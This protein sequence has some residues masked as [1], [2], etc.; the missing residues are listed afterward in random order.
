MIS[1][2]QFFHFILYVSLIIPWNPRIFWCFCFFLFSRCFFCFF[3]RGCFG[4]CGFIG[5][6]AD[7][8]QRKVF[9]VKRR[10]SVVLCICFHLTL[11]ILSQNPKTKKSW[12]KQ[13]NR[14]KKEHEKRGASQRC[15]LERPMTNGKFQPFEDVSAITNG[16]FSNVMLVFRGVYCI[17]SKTSE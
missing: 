11:A 15:F 12:R 9:F 3:S 8:S 17:P 10:I 14:R 16:D 6:S 1:S 4:C 7:F 5:S 2:I 13:K